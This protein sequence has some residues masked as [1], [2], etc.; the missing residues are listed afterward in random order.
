[1]EN[2]G[3]NRWFRRR[4][5]KGCRE[6][7]V[8]KDLTGAKFNKSYEILAIET[9]NQAMADFLFTLGCYE[10]QRV[11][12]LSSLGDNYVIHIKDARYSIDQALAR[13]IR[14]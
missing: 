12:V 9:E 5:R 13:A 6:A 11:H 4:A 1:M 10:G 2:T 8:P 14:I 3:V 7:A